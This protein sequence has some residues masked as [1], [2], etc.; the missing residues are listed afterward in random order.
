MPSIKPSITING[1]SS[2]TISGLII[3]ALPPISKPAMRAVSE[4]IDGRD[5]DEITKLGFSAYDKT[6]QIALAGS[7]DVNDVIRYFNQDGIITFS[8][9]PDKYYRF[10]QL[11]GIDFEKLIRYKTA[12]VVFHCQPFKF[13][14]TDEE[15][16]FFEPSSVSITNA[17]N[18]YSKPE[19]ALTGHGNMEMRINGSPVLAVDFGDEQQTIIIDSEKMNAYGAKS[20]IKS[21]ITEI[22]PQQDLHGYDSAWMDAGD[23]IPYLFRKTAGTASRFGNGIIDQI[24]GGSVVFNQLYSSNNVSDTTHNGIKF[25]KQPDRS[26]RVY[27][28]FDSVG[29][30]YVSI[31]LSYQFPSYL[32]HKYFVTTNLETSQTKVWYNQPNPV[33]RLSE[34]IGNIHTLANGFYL[35]AYGDEGTTIDERIKPQIIDLTQMFGTAI[36]DYLYNL[37][38]ATAGAGVSILRKLFPFTFYGYN[39]GELISVKTSAHVI[40]GLNQWD[41]ETQQGY[42]NGQ[43]GEYFPNETREICSKNYI[44]ILSKTEYYFHRGNAST[45]GDLIFYDANKNFLSSRLNRGNQIT[46]TPENAH[47]MQINLGNDYGTTYN[48]NVC[49]NISKPSLNG[50]YKAYSEHSYSLDSSLDLRGLF[51]L[52]ANNNL[53]CDGDEYSSNGNVM[54]KYGIV[55]LGSLTWGKAGANDDI[56]ATNDLRGIIKPSDF[57]SETF[58][59]LCIPYISARGIDAY[60]KDIDCCIGCDGNGRTYINDSAKASFTP[61]QFITSLN[62]KML[63]YEKETA[64]TETAQP[65][66]NPQAIEPDGSEEYVDSRAIPLVVGHNT[67]HTNICEIDGWNACNVTRTGKN[68]AF[69]DHGNNVVIAHLKAGQYVFSMENRISVGFVLRKNIQAGAEIIGISS[70]N[71][72][73]TYTFNLDEEC[74]VFMN[75]WSNVSGQGFAD[76]TGKFQ[77]ETGSE[78]TDFEDYEGFSKVIDWNINQ[79]D[80]EWEIGEIDVN[81]GA[82]ISDNSHIRSKNFNP[83]IPSGKYYCVEPTADNNMMLFFY[84]ASK[85]FISH[86]SWLGNSTIVAP[87]NAYFF[88]FK[89]GS[90]Y[91][92]EYNGDISI[93]FPSTYTDYHAYVGRGMI[94]KAQ[95][96]IKTGLM[97]ILGIMASVDGTTG[98]AFHQIEDYGNNIRARVN[99]SDELPAGLY[100][101]SNTFI[102]CDKIQPSYANTIGLSPSSPACFAIYPH[103]TGLFITM[104]KEFCNSLDEANDFIRSCKPIIVYKLQSPIEFYLTATELMSLIGENHIFTNTG[105]ISSC[106]YVRDGADVET[107]GE[108]ITFIADVGD[109]ISDHLKNRLCI[110]NYDNIRLSTGINTISFHPIEE[111]SEIDEMAISKYSRWL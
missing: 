74:D 90:P 33:W 91:G 32:N 7:Y 34:G 69:V 59:G 71:P 4:E 88:K 6:C 35:I 56:F 3:V 20:N 40:R 55:D 36:A 48:H 22:N 41:E 38:Q 57:E 24:N 99:W 62:G 103:S 110:G 64:T 26:I 30:G 106:V 100:E 84:D 23:R 104:P 66:T 9:E 13:S 10:K 80:E 44:P 102:M 8:N 60:R 107:S 49:I 53:Y 70:Y 108:I 54:R 89:M 68:L 83:C 52:D 31:L 86:S 51:K 5:G 58:K 39:T 29:L 94:Y 61:E 2:T 50:I 16:T 101:S 42:W 73:L 82:P 43:T 87:A 75:G 97:R 111:G 14:T 17:G 11:E 98:K 109:I 18:I 27:G 96:N 65:F 93:N 78:K 63:I 12:S 79:W 15:L 28:T 47:Y 77:I 76:N 46:E 21:L 67:M 19:I 72:E 1:I 95:L 81:T 37:E 85:N 45:K 25:E 105:E 92:T